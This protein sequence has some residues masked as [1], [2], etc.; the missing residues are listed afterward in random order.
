MEM[1]DMPTSIPRAGF[2]VSEISEATTIGRSLIYRLIGCRKI[3]FVKVG[4]RTIVTITP[5]DLLAQFETMM[6]DVE[7]ER[8]AARDRS[9]AEAAA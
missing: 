1:Q 8:Q 9:L 6:K 5:K 3:P 2:T 4:D 7:A